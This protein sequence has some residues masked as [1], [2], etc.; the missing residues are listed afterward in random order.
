MFLGILKYFLPRN[1]D[2]SLLKILTMLLGE[3]DFVTSI[4]KDENTFWLT[5]IIFAMFL[6]S[7]SIVLMNLVVGLA[8]HDIGALR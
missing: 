6:L 2:N 4:L 7:M 1:L 5:K 8:I 3:F